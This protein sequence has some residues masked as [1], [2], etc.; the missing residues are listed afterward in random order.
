VDPAIVKYI[1]LLEVVTIDR[2]EPWIAR[3][4]KCRGGRRSLGRYLFLPRSS[5]K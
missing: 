1:A 4:T 2:T 5:P 3:R